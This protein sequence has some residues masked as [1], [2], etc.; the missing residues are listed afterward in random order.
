MAYEEFDQKAIVSLEDRLRTIAENLKQ[1]REIAATRDG[2][3]VTLQLGSFQPYLK[4]LEKLSFNALARARQEKYADGRLALLLAASGFC[5]SFHTLSIA[6][7]SPTSTVARNVVNAF[8]FRFATGY[9]CKHP[10][11]FHALRLAP[12]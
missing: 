5:S 1:V 9:S 10:S 4:R 3:T 8:D 11:T 7:R 6:D 12:F 2:G